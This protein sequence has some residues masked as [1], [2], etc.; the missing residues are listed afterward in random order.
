MKVLY[1]SLIVVIIDQITKI[2][3]K[4]IYI[5]FLNFNII[6]LDKHQSIKVIGDFLQITFVE[7]PGMAF[8]IGVNSSVKLFLSLF[9]IAAI[10]GVLYYLYLSRNERFIFRFALAL[11]LGGAFGNL[12]DRVFYGVIYNYAPL[13]YGHVVDF[14]NVEFFDFKLFG[15]SYERFPIFNIADSAVSIGVVLL[16]FFNKKETKK[17]EENIDEEIKN[18]EQEDTI[19]IQPDG[20]ANN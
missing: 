4:G 8:G 7:N 1:Y 3:V 11:I 15:Q 9:T 5:P 12:I 13:F 6:G 20:K 18:R 14:I 17:V 19:D 16:L 10:V 2:L